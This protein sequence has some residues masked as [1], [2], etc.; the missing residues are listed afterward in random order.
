MAELSQ[1]EI[2]NYGLLLK[3]HFHFNL[4]DLCSTTNFSTT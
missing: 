2:M 4:T 1:F 3:K